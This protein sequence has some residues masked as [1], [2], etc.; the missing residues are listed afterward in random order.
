M[1]GCHKLFSTEPN[2]IAIQMYCA[3]IACLLLARV[4]GGRVRMDVFRMLCFYMQGLAT[5]AELEAYLEKAREKESR[6]KET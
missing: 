1:L 4:T 3:I 5:M 6:Q 2:A